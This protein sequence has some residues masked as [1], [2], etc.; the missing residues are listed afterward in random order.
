MQD[1]EEVVLVLVD[2]RA[3]PLRE[4]V[5]DVEL[6]EAKPIGEEDRLERARLVYVDPGE[7]VSGKL[8]DAGLGPL[9]NV[10]RGAAGSST[11]DAG[12]SRPCHW[13]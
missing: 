11:P 8:G 13:Y 3:L 2:L 9:D 4:H 12:Q 7:S 6:V 1:D 5:L 10:A